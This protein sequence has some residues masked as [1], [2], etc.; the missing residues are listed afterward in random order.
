MGVRV[1][2]VPAA[3]AVG[4]LVLGA[5]PVT[6]HVTRCPTAAPCP[7]VYQVVLHPGR[8]ASALVLAVLAYAVTAVLAAL[9]RA[10]KRPALP[11]AAAPRAVAGLT[12]AVLAGPAS[13]AVGGVVSLVWGS[14]PRTT[15]WERLPVGLLSAGSVAAVLLGVAVVTVLVTLRATARSAPA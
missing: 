11:G 5:L 6:E 10:A 12:A 8:L 3:A 9:V 7:S 13:A 1:S 4:A 15:G 14:A 2:R